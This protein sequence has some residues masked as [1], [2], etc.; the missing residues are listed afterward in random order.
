MWCLVAVAVELG[1][2]HPA[3]ALSIVAAESAYGDLA[4]Q[5]ASPD[6]RVISLLTNPA[7]DPHLYEPAPSAARAL[8]EADI[9]IFNGAGYDAWIE[10]LLPSGKPA[11]SVAALLHRVA[12]DNPHLWYDP[13][14]APALVRALA[15]QLA[16]ADP[17]HAD[18]V[19]ARARLVL[20]RLD[21]LQSRI[22]ELR[23]RYAGAR[24]AATEPVLGPL[25]AAIGLADPHSRFELAVMNGTEPRP[26]DIAALQGD[27]QAHRVRALIT[28]VQASNPAAARL[29][30]VAH[31][32]GLPVVAVSETLPEGQ[33]YLAW[34][35]GVLDL[36]Q[37]ALARP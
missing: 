11:I 19:A 28:N 18:T 1:M 24:V 4:R 22:V 26:S 16:R 3:C 37:A 20:G 36:L 31:A 25:L 14:A 32:S 10:R 5:V 29:V 9:V 23:S 12:G 17:A 34:M 35:G 7:I 2:V 21:A 27:L 8:A 6:T 13:L 15:V 33:S 30:D